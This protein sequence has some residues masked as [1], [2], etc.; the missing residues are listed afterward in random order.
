MHIYLCVHR[1]ARA[2]TI[3]CEAGGGAGAGAGAAPG[4]AW[5]MPSEPQMETRGTV[6]WFLG[7]RMRRGLRDSRRQPRSAA[8]VG[9]LTT[10]PG[11]VGAAEVQDLGR[12]A[13]AKGEGRQKGYSTWYSQA[14]S[15]PS[16]NQARPCLAFAIIGDQARSEW[17]GP[18]RRWLLLGALRTLCCTSLPL[19]PAG[20][21]GRLAC[22]TSPQGC[23]LYL[24]HKTRDWTPAVR[25]QWCHPAISSSIVPFSS[26]PQSLP[27]SESFP[28]SQLFAW[29][30]HSTGVSA[31]VS[32]FQ[33]KPRTDLL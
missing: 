29:G 18:R 30:G 26:C 10:H 8:G 6:V 7:S 25:S 24:S 16:T 17:C 11:R 20:R 21:A 23:T 3:A 14:V 5:G 1:H 12:G 2:R 9:A 32:V 28:M 27:A 19:W 33:W 4:I 31:L 13:G 15:H 22:C